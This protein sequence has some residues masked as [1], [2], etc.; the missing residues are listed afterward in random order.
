MVCINQKNHFKE[1][2]TQESFEIGSNICK[3]RIVA[4]IYDSGKKNSTKIFQLYYNFFV[5]SNFKEEKA[6]FHP[7]H[8][9]QKMDVQHL[10]LKP[11]NKAKSINQSINQ[12][13]NHSINQSIKQAINQSI[14]QSDN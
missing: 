8:K 5:Y 2:K 3:A 14:N 11:M 1:I 4:K 10:N 12:S 13:T 7:I 6:Y 9:R